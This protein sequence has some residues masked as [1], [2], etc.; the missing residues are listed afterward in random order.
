MEKIKSDRLC[1]T[2]T[3]DC[4][5]DADKADMYHIETGEIKRYSEIDESDIQNWILHDSVQV[6]RDADELE[7]ESIEFTEAE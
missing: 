5:I 2:L 3:I 6:I 7:H 1:I 4:F